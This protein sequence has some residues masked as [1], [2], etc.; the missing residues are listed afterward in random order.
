MNV[1]CELLNT[2]KEFIANPAGDIDILLGMESC[3]LLLKAQPLDR[4]PFM[5]D[6]SVTKSPL[7]SLFTVTGDIGGLEGDGPANCVHSVKTYTKNEA[8]LS[9]LHSTAIA[10]MAAN[11]LPIGMEAVDIMLKQARLWI[12]AAGHDPSDI[13]R[14]EYSDSVSRPPPLSCK[15]VVAIMAATRSP[16]M[17]RMKVL[18]LVEQGLLPRQEP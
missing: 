3:G 18:A 11:K 7:S 1:L 17:M 16:K 8:Y 13:H 6:L 9:N 15:A 14:I 10:L 5:R 2:R 12:R 4:T